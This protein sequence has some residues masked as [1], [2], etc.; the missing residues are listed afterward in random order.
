MALLL[1]FH[2]FSIFEV[3]QG[4]VLLIENKNPSF[5]VYGSSNDRRKQ[6]DRPAP[7]TLQIDFLSKVL[8]NYHHLKKSTKK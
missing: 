3:F 5:Q 4:K 6:L 1:E 2:P 7:Q 8:P